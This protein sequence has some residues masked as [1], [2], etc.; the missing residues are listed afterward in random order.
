MSVTRIIGLVLVVIGIVVLAWGGVFWTRQKTVLDAGPLEVKT[1]QHEGVALPP[2]VG[3]GCL[4]AG[5]ALVV[6][7]GRQRA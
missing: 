4:V 6:V 1:Q 7:G 2:I 3:V 5:I